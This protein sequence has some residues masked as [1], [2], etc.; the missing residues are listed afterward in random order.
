MA[1]T[2]H[3]KRISKE[4]VFCG[5]FLQVIN[6]N[7]PRGGRD[8][9]FASRP[10]S[11]PRSIWLSKIAIVSWIHGLGITSWDTRVAVG[12][13]ERGGSKLPPRDASGGVWATSLRHGRSERGGVSFPARAASGGVWPTSL[14]H[15]RTSGE[16]LESF[17]WP[18]PLAQPRV[19]N[20]T[21]E[22]HLG[23]ASA[24]SAAV[25]SGD[26]SAEHGAGPAPSRSPEQLPRAAKG[27]NPSAGPIRWHSRGSAITLGHCIGGSFYFVLKSTHQRRIECHRAG[28]S[29]GPRE[30]AE[31]PAQGA[32][33]VRSVYV[34]GA[35]T[36]QRGGPAA[37]PRGT[38]GLPAGRKRAGRSPFW[39][40]MW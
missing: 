32:P 37:C 15:G 5:K 28:G 20:N 21:G 19:G 27:W 25:E 31:P 6:C 3:L 17:R 2:H 36:R 18:D 38:R 40:C 1:R 4:N 33:P 30:L 16:G 24:R 29:G 13:S 22:L 7:L 23:A 10:L 35:A 26:P 8:G 34:G 12:N 11:G 39:R 9:N 14:R